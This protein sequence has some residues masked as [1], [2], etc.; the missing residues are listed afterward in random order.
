MERFLKSFDFIEANLDQPLTLAE[1]A[2]VACYSSYHYARTI[3][4]LTGYSVMGYLAARRL[5]CAAQRPDGE[6]RL[7][8][9]D[10]ALKSGY[11]RRPLLPGP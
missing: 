9:I 4:A 7:R 6:A 11:Q 10:L 8:L 2:G 3:R 1:I 5:S